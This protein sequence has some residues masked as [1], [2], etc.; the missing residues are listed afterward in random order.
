MECYWYRGLLPSHL[1]AVDPPPSEECWQVSHNDDLNQ[2]YFG[3]GSEL[4]PLL[5][6]GDASGG[7]DTH[8]PRLRRIGLAVSAVGEEPGP[9]SKFVFGPLPG[10]RQTVPR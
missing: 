5:I 3:E 8:D 9:D 1:T 2:H 4:E 7:C 6:H 10:P